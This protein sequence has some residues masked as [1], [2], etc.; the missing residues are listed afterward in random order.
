MALP[1]VG[2]CFALHTEGSEEA[3]ERLSLLGAFS[4]H[5]VCNPPS[6]RLSCPA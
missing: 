6:L 1:K 2:V 4:W 3:W 5:L